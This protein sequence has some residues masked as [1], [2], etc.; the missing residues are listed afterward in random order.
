LKLISDAVYLFGVV[1][2]ILILFSLHIWM[3]YVWLSATAYLV[4]KGRLIVKERF[5]HY[6]LL[7]ISFIL[8]SYGFYMIVEKILL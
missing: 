3:D 6:F 2:G 1:E 4:S 5:Y 7:A 8:A